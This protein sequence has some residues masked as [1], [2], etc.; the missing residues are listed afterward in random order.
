MQLRGLL[1]RK[2]TEVI[3]SRKKS[4]KKIKK[5]IKK[6]TKKAVTEIESLITKDMKM[7]ER[8]F[9]GRFNQIRKDLKTLNKL[10]K[11]IIKQNRK[12]IRHLKKRKR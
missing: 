11:N 8:D 4:E 1:Y 3:K 2:L 9:N 10:N 7:I 6:E 12:L 5:S